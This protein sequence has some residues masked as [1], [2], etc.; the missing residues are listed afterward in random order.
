MAKIRPI[1]STDIRNASGKVSVAKSDS[2]LYDNASVESSAIFG[3]KQ[4]IKSDY[5]NTEIYNKSGYI[6]LAM[7]VLN[8]FLAGS[9]CEVLKKILDVDASKI[10]DGQ[11]IYDKKNNRVYTLQEAKSI[12]YSKDLLIGG[13]YLEYVIDNFDVEAEIRKVL[14]GMIR[15]VLGAGND[16]P[17]ET[18]G[19]I[20]FDGPIHLVDCYYFVPAMRIDIEAASFRIS[21][22]VEE[23]LDN[24]NSKLTYLMCLRGN[25]DRLRDQVLHNVFVLPKGYRPEFRGKSDD[26]TVAYDNVVRQNNALQNILLRKN[27]KLEAVRAAYI[28]LLK[29]VRNVMTD[30]TNQYDKMFKPLVNM[31]KGKKGLIRDKMQGTRID[32]SGRSVII[33]DPT[34][35]LDTIG[36]P[37]TMLE[38]LLELDII[39]EY[40]TQKVNKADVLL[41]NNKHLRRKMAE[42]IGERS[43]I[44]TGRQPTLYNLG[45]RGFKVKPVQ[46]EAIVLS[47]LTTLAFNA[48]FDGD[49]M[50]LETPISEE[51]KEEVKNLMS[52]VNNV[53]LPRSGDCHIAPRQEI[54]HGLWKASVATEEREGS[55]KVTVQTYN[56]L[57]DKVCSQEINIYDV[58]TIGS[59][60]EVAGKAAIRAC[61]TKELRSIRLGVSPITMDQS[62]QEVPVTEGW[63]KEFNK[64]LYLRDKANFVKVVD[65]TVKLGF[66]VT[67]IFPPS[68]SVIKYPDVHKY[69]EEFEE[70]VR[71]REEYFNM[72]LEPESAY[73]SYY[74]KKYRELEA[75]LN[76]V[77]GA[78]LG[79]ESGYVEMVDS[80]A[81][82]NK[83][84]LRQIFGMK[85][86]VMK[87]ESEAFNAIIDTSLVE[88]LTGLGH[89]IT[90]YGGRQG[91]IDKS[92]QTYG[93]G[94][95][96]RKLS[97]VTSPMYIT[98]EDC[99]TTD[100]LLVDFEFMKQFVADQLTGNDLIDNKTVRN[101]VVKMIVGRS[102]IGVPREIETEDEAAAAY[103][104]LVATVK[105]GELV[106]HEG[107]KIRSPLK[108]KNPCC[109]KCYGKDLAT[110]RT[111]LVGTPVGAL[112]SGSIGEPGTQLIMKNFQNGGVAGVKNLTSSF[113]LTNSYT[114]LYNLKKS[115][116]PINYDYI[117]PVSGEVVTVSRGN[118]T[119]F[120]QIWGPGAN[121]KNRNLLGNTKVILYE[122][123][124]VKDYVEAG[125][126]IQKRQGFMNMHEVMEY[127]GIEY[128]QRYLAVFLF[129][130]YQKEAF[131]SLKYFELL[132][133]CMTFKLCKK[134]N[135]YF[136]SG[137]YYMLQEYY[138]HDTKGCEF[139]D[140]MKGIADVPLYRNDVFS[141]MFMEDI[142]AGI[143]RSIIT[144]GVDE[145]K[146][147]IIRY[148][149]GL[150]ANL[151][152]AVPGYV[153]SRGNR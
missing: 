132:V 100:G 74:D 57:L 10:A 39:E 150:G 42:E 116:K 91:L 36:V 69:I 56:E 60:T 102:I 110:N 46:G 131:V 49:Q 81:R 75:T 3:T 8:Y 27:V 64:F 34:M 99:G 82:G 152:S 17:N 126:T 19:Q 111:V 7:P 54:I 136:K 78:G 43:Y 6:S 147:P 121:G 29:A 48:D 52:V 26:I 25:K 108:C 148:S 62:V 90:A 50:H 120:L 117:A 65:K 15:K 125:E 140:T 72:G 11:I 97:H 143:S 151:G 105:D 70:D 71:K 85:G 129:N 80:G 59:K 86:R 21:K 58:V 88:Q 119:K 51:A 37:I 30:K 130:I 133:A 77:I 12:D 118:G 20:E 93:P 18:I 33:S 9:K 101:L 92:I 127:R 83:S 44:I 67:N 153:E 40:K 141:T 22:C 113:D 139:I 5:E 14:W 114:H 95:F 142:R 84:N 135:D 24:Y 87:D 122:D 124:E 16:T 13:E 2:V 38:K 98:E 45:L 145:M 23:E 134:G 63:F 106:V 68:I 35:P 28:D 47:P 115:G 79:K 31:L 89:M 107:L 149:F 144:S 41:F 1:K 32:Y 73:T 146:L 94:Y 109:V 137:I 123:V 53:F 104:K 76:K 66:A 138:A 128:A 55:R 61:F 96:S 112:A 103:D 4:G